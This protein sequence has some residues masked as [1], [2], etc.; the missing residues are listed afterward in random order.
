MSNHPTTVPD[1]SPD[2]S[3]TSQPQAPIYFRAY[4]YVSNRYQLLLDAS[5]PHWMARWAF[6]LSILLVFMIRILVAQGWYIICYGLSIYYLN[7]FICFLSPKI[8]PAFQDGGE[9]DLDDSPTGPMLPT[10]ASDEFRPFIRRLPEFKFWLSAT[11]ATIIS[12]FLTL[13]EVFD[14]PVFWPILLV[15]FI[16]LFVSTMRAQIKHMI[17]YGYVPWDKGKTKYG[18]PKVETSSLY[19]DTIY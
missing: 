7:L 11:K 19:S 8:D 13:F 15:Y 10:K 14:L 12:L 1:P 17:K 9:F 5:T 4:N 18:T 16:L 3:F 2:D 6:S